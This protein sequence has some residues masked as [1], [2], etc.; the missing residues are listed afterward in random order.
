MATP[1]PAPAPSAEIP[2]VDEAR[3]LARLR[4][5]EEAAFDDLVCMAGGR[6]L[7]VAR[8]MLSNE[9]DAGDAVQ[10]AFLNAPP[11]STG[12]QSTPA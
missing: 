2:L 11:G 8:R 1:A 6:M 3:L 12:S 7:A 9:E 4:A 10:D 5:G